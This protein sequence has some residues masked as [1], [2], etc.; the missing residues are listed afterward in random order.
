MIVSVSVSLNVTLSVNVS[1]KVSMKVSVKVK[2]N[3][4]KVYDMV[5]S[6]FERICDFER[7][8]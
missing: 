1:V 4:G 3:L 7:T 2:I 8:I 5:M 6:I